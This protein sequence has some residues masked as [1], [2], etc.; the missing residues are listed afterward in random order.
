MTYSLLL[1]KNIKLAYYKNK[2]WDKW[3]DNAAEAADLGYTGY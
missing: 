1:N 3:P 2:K